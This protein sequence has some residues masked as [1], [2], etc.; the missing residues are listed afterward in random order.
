MEDVRGVAKRLLGALPPG[1]VVEG[2]RR[3]ADLAG[4]LP[5]ILDRPRG[6]REEKDGLLPQ[7]APGFGVDF[8]VVEEEARVAGGAPSKDHG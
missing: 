5:Y 2:Q 7:A 8:V 1:G 4:L 3:V 6:L